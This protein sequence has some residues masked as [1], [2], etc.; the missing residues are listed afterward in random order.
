M[1]VIIG[2]SVWDALQAEKERTVPRS[3]WGFDS[4]LLC[5]WQER[6]SAEG[7][8]EIELVESVYG[9]SVRYASGLQDFGLLAGLRKGNLDGSL[10]AALKYAQ[11]WVDEDPTKR[12]CFAPDEVARICHA[13]T[14]CPA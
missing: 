7:H 1:T 9:W 3:A 11:A 2:K 10:E 12:C 5:R 4:Q 6:K 14:S 8:K 13:S